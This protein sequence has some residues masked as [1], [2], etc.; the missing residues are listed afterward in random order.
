M[1]A[2]LLIWACMMSSSML[3]E[4]QLSSKARSFIC[5]AQAVQQHIC[6]NIMP[7]ASAGPSV[8]CILEFVDT[9]E[10]L[11]K[12]TPPFWHSFGMTLAC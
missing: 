9:A 2:S 10:N 4:H 8:L 11:V 5:H 1:P 6:C 3:L 7:T 12:Y